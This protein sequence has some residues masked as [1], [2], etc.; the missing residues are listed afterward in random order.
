MTLSV[1]RRDA[2]LMVCEALVTGTK[3]GAG[4]KAQLIEL[5][6]YINS[7]RDD[8]TLPLPSDWAVAFMRGGQISM[9]LRIEL[10]PDFFSSLSSPVI[11]SKTLNL[12][13]MSGDTFFSSFE[14]KAVLELYRHMH[15]WS[16]RCDAA[17][18]SVRFKANLG[19]ADRVAMS[20]HMDRYFVSVISD[21]LREQRQAFA[22]APTW[23][24]TVRK[25][26]NTCGL[27]LR[28]R[29]WPS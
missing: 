3:F 23:F 17:K 16:R 9:E 27:S 7:I 28:V 18:A 11:V 21:G 13:H 26:D 25:W 19:G 20:A 6:D 8:P 12:K 29:R 5:R 14:S 4:P 2:V 24:V 1:P 22:E 15:E 10:Y